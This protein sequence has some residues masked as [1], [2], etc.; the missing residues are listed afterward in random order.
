VEAL[1]GLIVVVLVSVS[2]LGLYML[3]VAIAGVRGVGVSSCRMLAL[4][5]FFSGWTIVG[6]FACL[7][8]AFAIRPQEV[9]HNVS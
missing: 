9:Q 3:P 8:I 4:A 7:L 2:L 6:W 5:N 1:I